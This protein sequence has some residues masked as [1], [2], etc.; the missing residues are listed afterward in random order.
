LGDI[1]LSEIDMAKS[2]RS[3]TVPL[4]AVVNDTGQ[5]PLTVTD[6][7]TEQAKQFR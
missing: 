3:H 7:I 4:P 2:S 6:W 5:A 1:Q